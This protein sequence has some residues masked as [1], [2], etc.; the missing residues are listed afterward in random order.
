MLQ[1]HRAADG[2]EAVEVVVRKIAERVVV[3]VEEVSVAE[4]MAEG[5]GAEVGAAAA[6][7]VHAAMH[8]R[9]W[10]AGVAEFV[11]GAAACSLQD[12]AGPC[13]P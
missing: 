9:A 10:A 11:A 7:F 2:V 8:E 1:G 5:S 6:A 13:D 4:G 3:A 12:S